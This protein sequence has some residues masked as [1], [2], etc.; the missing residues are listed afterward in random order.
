MESF[1]S[2]E[3]VCTSLYIVTGGNGRGSTGVTINFSNDFGVFNSEKFKVSKVAV[4]RFRVQL[5]IR[6]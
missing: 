6:K 2:S 4:V 5:R 3:E 1:P